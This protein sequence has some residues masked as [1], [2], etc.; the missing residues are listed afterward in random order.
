MR[1]TLDA[2]I[3]APVGLAMTVMEDL[4]GL[5]GKGRSRVEQEISNARVAGKY[6][7]GRVPASDV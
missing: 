5:I 7:V 2:C 4:P 3:F 1:R 6:V